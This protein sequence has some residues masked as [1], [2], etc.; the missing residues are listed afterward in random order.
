VAVRGLEIRTAT[1]GDATGL[2]TLL[3]EAGQIVDA[4][5]FTERLA[6]LRQASGTA[7]V[8]IQWG[9]PIGVLVMHWYQ[10]LEADCP[11]AQITTLLVGAEDRRRGIGRLLIKAAAQAARMAGCG[12]L[13]V[14]TV[15][16]VTSVQNFC[17]ANGFT[18][19][20][21]RFIRLLRKQV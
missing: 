4:S 16:G 9:P 18:E 3:A 13:E 2:A 10:T 1:A 5:A 6:A 21:P 7:L 11:V 15:S 8:A 12:E 19:T 17:R 14:V 20:G